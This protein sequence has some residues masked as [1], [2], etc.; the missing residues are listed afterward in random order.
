M[1][2]PDIPGI[3]CGPDN[4]GKPLARTRARV[5][6]KRKPNEMNDR[7]G[8]QKA[9]PRGISPYDSVLLRREGRETKTR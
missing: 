2:A 7:E 5:E 4:N 1:Y 9:K 3:H 6:G 8:V